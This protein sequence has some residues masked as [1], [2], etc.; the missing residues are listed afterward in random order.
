[1]SATEIAQQ[2]LQ[3]LGAGNMAEVV[4]LFAPEGMVHSPIYGHLPARE[5][6]E[7]LAGDTRE[8]RLELLRVFEEPSASQMALYFNYHWLM[9]NGEEVHFE[10]VDIIKLNAK[11]QITELRI[12]YDTVQARALVAKE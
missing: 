8:S 7:L 4:S 5:F 12:I 2:Y 9:A 6:Y 1:M 3:A 10:V 11:R